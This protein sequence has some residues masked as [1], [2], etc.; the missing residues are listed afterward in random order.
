VDT[1][2]LSLHYRDFFPLLLQHVPLPYFRIVRY[3]GLYSNR[4]KI[5]E[6]YLSNE[7]STI[8]E[9]INDL[10]IQEE[11]EQL[12]CSHC[13]RKKEYQH[14]VVEKRKTSKIDQP[15]IIIYKRLFWKRRTAA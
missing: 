11:E 8:N 1:F 14:T 2:E 12:Y 10:E 3:Y 13:K 5:P 6:E 15:E 7:T 4:G 9:Q